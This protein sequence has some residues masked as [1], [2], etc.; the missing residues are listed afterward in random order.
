[1]LGRERVPTAPGAL[2]LAGVAVLAWG[3]RLLGRKPPASAAGIHFLR[4][5]GAYSIDKARRLLGYAPAVSLEEGMRGV[6]RD[7][8]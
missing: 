8:R 6:A 4:R 5:R 1:M 3:Y 7:L 2:L